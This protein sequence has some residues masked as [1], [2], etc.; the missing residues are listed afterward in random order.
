MS[1]TYYRKGR[2]QGRV[3]TFHRP[4]RSQ[5][6]PESVKPFVPRVKFGTVSIRIGDE[7][8]TFRVTRWDASRLFALGKPQA[9]ST[10]GK[11]IALT[12]ENLL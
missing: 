3:K 10:I 4:P 9:A 6:A 7:S 8:R 2:Y 5:F 11:R 1:A 12:L